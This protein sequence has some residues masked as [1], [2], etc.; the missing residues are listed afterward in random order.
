M[1]ILEN[2]PSFS[3]IEERT[4]NGTPLV[5]VIFPDGTSDNLVLNKYEDMEGHFIGHL[6]NEPDACVAMVNHPEHAELTILSN[7]VVGSTM[8]KWYNNGDVELVPEVFSNGLERDEVM[9]RNIED[10]E[11]IV[12]QAEEVEEGIIENL[13]SAAQAKSVPK[14][15]KLQIKVWSIV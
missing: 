3:L 10:D 11:P 14:T 6:E 5:E 8:Y 15:A 13:L 12:D 1:Y 4:L 2:L 9:E 7:R